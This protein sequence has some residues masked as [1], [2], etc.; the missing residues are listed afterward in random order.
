M[1]EALKVINELAKKGI[2]K[3]YAVG[4]GIATILYTEPLLTYDLDVFYVPLEEEQGRSNFCPLTT[5]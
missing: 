4:G 3:S 2:I 1:D 5:S